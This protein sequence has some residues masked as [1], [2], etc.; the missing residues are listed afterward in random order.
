MS[1]MILEF[2]DIRVPFI[3]GKKNWH[4]KYRRSS[5]YEVNK[6]NI[7]FREKQTGLTMVAIHYDVS[8]FGLG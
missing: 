8:Y 2:T 7:I 3:Y 6:D 4:K 1:S 5:M